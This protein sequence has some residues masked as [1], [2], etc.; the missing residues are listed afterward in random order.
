[1]KRAMTFL[2]VAGLTVGVL[3]AAGCGKT[4]V[5]KSDETVCVFD[6]STRGAQKLKF[7]LLPGSNAR[8]TDGNDEIVHIPASYR[9]YAAFPDRSRADAGAPSYYVGYAEGNVVVHVPGQFRFKFDL[10]N[11]CEWYAKH[12]RRNARNGDLGFN[13]RSGGAASALSPWVRWLNEN[14]GTVAQATVSSASKGYT[15]PQLV[16]GNDPEAQALSEP[17][18]ISYGKNI[19][20]VFTARLEK[21]LGGKFFCGTDASLW[22]DPNVNSDCPP[23]Y[24]EVGRVTTEDPGLMASREKTEK[25][26]A[27]A[28]NQRIQQQI[29]ADAAESQARI[30]SA[31][32]TAQQKIRAARLKTELAAQKT[33][34]RLLR[35]KV[36]TAELQAKTNAEYWKCLA[37]A[38]A[39]LDCTGRRPDVIVPGTALPSR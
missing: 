2:A 10:Q 8:K 36:K 13:A 38:R 7:Q 29:A 33:Q 25:L 27:E 3:L 32:A 18:D 16:Y 28:E 39:G 4:A 24:F 23:I 20:R 26:R 6:G 22:E 14:F 31:N 9:F 1:M 12:G 11:A 30:D 19:G 34:Q 35:L 17:V 21:S 5:A 15:W 37:Y